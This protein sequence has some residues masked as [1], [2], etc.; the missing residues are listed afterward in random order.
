MESVVPGSWILHIKEGQGHQR[1]TGGA[2]TAGLCQR[3]SEFYPRV[4]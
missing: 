1:V 3:M 2:R 4:N